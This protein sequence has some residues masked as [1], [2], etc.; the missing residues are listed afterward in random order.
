MLRGLW[1]TLPCC[2]RTIGRS[3]LCGIGWATWEDMLAILDDCAA[4]DVLDDLERYAATRAARW[5][6]SAGISPAR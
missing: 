2:A 3:A 5:L 4:A 6:R 1:R